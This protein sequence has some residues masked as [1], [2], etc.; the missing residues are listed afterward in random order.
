MAPGGQNDEQMNL[1]RYFYLPILSLHRQTTQTHG[2]RHWARLT[3]RQTTLAKGLGPTS[4]KGPTKV[5]NDGKGA[6]EKQYEAN[7]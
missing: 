7:L 1:L 4:K 5:I 2:Q 3:L 6:Y